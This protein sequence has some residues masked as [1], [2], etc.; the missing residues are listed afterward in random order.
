MVRTAIPRVLTTLGATA[1]LRQCAAGSGAG[2][3]RQPCANNKHP[4]RE[5]LRAP[6]L[7]DNTGAIG[8]WTAMWRQALPGEGPP[9]RLFAPSWWLGMCAIRFA[10]KTGARR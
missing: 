1:V 4:M 2:R 7:P 8:P 5:T 9:V 10:H 6:G 3:C